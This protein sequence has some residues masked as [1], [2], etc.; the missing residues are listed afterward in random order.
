[1]SSPA[2]GSETPAADAAGDSVFERFA[3]GV[4]R[5]LWAQAW[6]ALRPIQEQAAR[7]VLDTDADVIIAAPTA[8]GK[9]EAAWLPICSKLVSAVHTDQSGHHR[10]V[11]PGVQALYIAPLKALINDQYARLSSLCEPLEIPVHRWHGDVP[12]ASKATVLDHPGGLL[13]I[14]PESLE[15]LFVNRGTQLPALLAGLTDIVIDELHS[16]LGTERGAQLQSLTHRVELALRR[17]VPRVGLSATLGD[18]RVASDFLRPGHGEHVVVVEDRGEHGELRA[19]L[20]GYLDTSPEAAIAQLY[21][22]DTDIQAEDDDDTSDADATIAAHLFSTLRGSDNLV[23]ANSRRMVEQL[24][25]RLARASAA[26]RVPN[27]FVAHH[28]NLSRDIREDAETR[29]KDPARPTTAVATSTLELGIDIGS[30]DSIAQ[31]GAPGT[32]SGSPRSCGRMSAR[33][34]STRVRACPTSS[35]AS[36]SRPSRCSSCCLRAGTRPRTWT[37]FTCRH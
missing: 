26:A 36:S 15:A 4:Q 23:F 37:R 29:L 21:D 6:P 10:G 3:P 16:F 7:A 24:T 19:Q 28:G 30:V 27:E 34:N 32:V 18:F 11:A 5:W 31:I 35:G 2:S 1:M 12:G 14:T 25:D 20:R 13:L 8:S 9:T 17:R 22:T 33:T